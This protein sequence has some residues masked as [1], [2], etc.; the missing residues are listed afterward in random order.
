MNQKVSED[1]E[2]PST[3]WQEDV[4]ILRGEGQENHASRFTF[5]GFRYVELTGLPEKPSPETVTGIVI[6]SD[7]PLTSSFECSNPMLNQ[8]YGNIIW[9]QRSNYL[10]VPTDCPQRDERLG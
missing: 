6:H 10:E 1:S 2:A 4:Y 5:H 7:A 8:L 9:G 3:A